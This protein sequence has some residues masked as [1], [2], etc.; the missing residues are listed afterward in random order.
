MFER[1]VTI[2]ER[3]A[4]SALEEVIKHARYNCAAFGSDLAFDEPV[5]DVTKSCPRPSN[6][7]QTAARIYFTTH[8]GGTSKSMK[9]RIALGEPFGAFVKAIVRLK[10]DARPQTADPLITIVHAARD[11]G[12]E[13]QSRN[14][15][16]CMLL[17][18]DFDAAAKRIIERASGSKRYRLG[19][20]LEEIAR[21]IDKHGVTPMRL[22]W[23]NPIK[24]TSNA[25]DRTSDIA[26]TA[27]ADKIPETEVF[28]ALAE[29]WQIID[30]PSDAILMGC[31]VLLHCAPWRI[32][33]VL[34]IAHDCEVEEQREG[35][36]G[37]VF[38][39]DGLPV[40]RYGIRY[41]REKS[42]D[43][44]IKWI[45]T[46][47][48][49]VAKSAIQR[50]R[51]A[52]AGAHELANWLADNPGRAWLPA[53]T[54]SA[55][56]H[57]LTTNDVQHVLGF[58]SP[59]AA[60][61]WLNANGVPLSDQQYVLPQFGAK[62][63]RVVARRDL[64]AALLRIMPSVAP[65]PAE[66]PL[67][68]RLFV[69]FVN[70]HHA[71]R[72]TIPCLLEIT[73]DQQIRDF[74]GGRRE[75][76][77]TV[78]ESGFSRLLNRPDLSVRTHQFRHWLNT[79]AQSGGLEQQLIARWSGR[80]ELAQNAEY[81]HLTPTELATIVREPLAKGMA[82]GALADIH[83]K[84]DPIERGSF[85]D[86]IVATAH[87]TEIGFCIHDWNTA[88]CPE[89]G[90]CSTCASFVFIKGDS[91]HRGRI[92]AMRAETAWVLARLEVQM[93]EGTRGASSHYRTM[94]VKLD[95]LDRILEFHNDPSI[96]DG[97]L[98]QP[99]SSS[100]IHIQS[101]REGRHDYG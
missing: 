28:V 3:N 40:M 27:R 22:D 44:D 50:I 5:W 83:A 43:P 85:R 84:R 58:S 24:K 12:E 31:V 73:S 91:K 26:V 60:L 86:V 77:K 30:N 89:F 17:A 32:I 71:K 51:Q 61:Q 13:L 94:R 19:A 75:D 39:R 56:D 8:E 6:K 57:A 53:D 65:G 18:E 23:K 10:Q 99:N 2:P 55:A 47:M 59:S 54:P 38:D 4:R 72:A 52:T 68:K 76:G 42:G 49:D 69:S 67:H 92:E 21:V 96:P 9:G 93:D 16:P 35:P 97:M 66:A 79:L 101:A 33:E 70:Q 25:R 1:I 87:V 80:D 48:V 78:I 90:A 34:R 45:P 20:A 46:V 81:D 41:W 64:E 14:N 63:R 98:I 37:P 11:L 74:L 7:S 100:P 62:T 15:D 88:P 95:S 36:D 82:I 29:I